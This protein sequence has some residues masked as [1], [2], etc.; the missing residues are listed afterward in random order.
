MKEGVK[1]G[2]K[3][4]NI[5]LKKIVIG[6]VKRGQ[7]TLHNILKNDSDRRGQEG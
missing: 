3:W 6:G 7:K 4:L 1:N 2:Q 5:V